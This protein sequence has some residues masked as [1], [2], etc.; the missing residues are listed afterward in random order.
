[1]CLLLWLGVGC[2]SVG[3]QASLRFGR[4][5][6]PESAP[7]VVHQAVRAANNIAGKPYKWGGGHASFYDSGYDCSGAVSHV[8]GKAGLLRSPMT[9][10]GFR[11]YGRP[12]RGRWITVYARNGH[13]FLVIAGLRFDTTGRGGGED[14]PGWRRSGRSLRGYVARHPPG[15]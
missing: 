13:T 15:L 3:P 11:D 2:A 1:M 6:A 7:P 8:L 4:A 9:S 5:K 10:R 14:G 12:G